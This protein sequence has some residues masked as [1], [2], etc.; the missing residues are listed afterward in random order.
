M[1]DLVSTCEYLLCSQVM[2][3]DLLPLDILDKC[4][5]KVFLILNTLLIHIIKWQ[6]HST[7]WHCELTFQSDVS[8]LTLTL[9]IP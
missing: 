3:V 2:K 1:N 8:G 5:L 9:C 4:M 7:N 6:S